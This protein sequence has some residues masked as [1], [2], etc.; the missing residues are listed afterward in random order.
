MKSLMMRPLQRCAALI[1]FWITA[2]SAVAAGPGELKFPVL[3]QTNLQ[4]FL[5]SAAT[6][7]DLSGDGRENTIVAGREELFAI[8]DKGKTL[9]RWR[10]K[11]R[12]MTYP[13]VL[14]RPGQP[15]LIYSADNS[16]LFTCLD[17]TGKIVWQA[18]LNGPSSWS[19]S[20]VCDLN[21]DGE[22]EVIQTDESGTVSAFAAL[23]GKLL[24]KTKI[25]GIPVSPA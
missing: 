13:A 18:Q 9:W 17:G 4:T 16:G 7:A 10:T 6:V 1:V 14:A 22:F 2:A 15:S 24:W 20:V 12:F 5:E 23:T 19:A 8:E 21:A 11:G 25:K 3:W